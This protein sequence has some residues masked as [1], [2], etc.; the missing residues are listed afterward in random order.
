VEPPQPP[1]PDPGQPASGPPKV[2]PRDAGLSEH[3]RRNRAAWNADADDYQARHGQQLA[4]D[5]KA[6]GT[7]NL[8]E[9]ELH[10][11]GDVAG[12]DILELGC[13]AAQGAIDL[14]RAGAWPVGLDLS[15]GQLAHARRLILEAG[16]EVALVQASAEAVPLADASFDLVFCDHG[17]M[18]FA[19]PYRTVPE[20]ARLLR[21]GGLFAFCHLSPIVDLCW[22][23]AA[24]RA[25]DRLV[26]DYFGMHRIEAVDEVVFQLP[27]GEWM[28]LFRAS[29][30]EILDLIEPRPAPDAVSSY[31]DD[32]DRAWARR[33][34]AECIWRLRRA[35]PPG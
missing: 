32:E 29:G 22:P 14:A 12:R 7:W 24:D 4:G 8:P 11:L 30:L 33:W 35:W 6:W 13:G 28:R 1:A 10:V 9:S 20:V 17:A 15:E 19:D 2:A 23:D 26:R 21:P 18:N 5:G 34:P 27:Y 3:A 16:V 31:R 25:G